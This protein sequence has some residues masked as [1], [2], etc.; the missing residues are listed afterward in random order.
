M[1][2]LTVNADPHVSYFRNFIFGVEDSLVSTVGLLSGIAV[3]GLSRA[4]IVITGAVLI[5]VEA[6]SMAAGSYLS[7]YS[8]ESYATHSE[9]PS[10]GD[11]VS[12]LIMFFSYFVTGFIP[13]LPY[14]FWPSDSALWVS[15][16]F[17]IAALLLLGVVGAKVA[18]I[19]VLKNTLRMVLVGS[20]AIAVGMLAGEL[21][22]QMN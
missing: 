18:R 15:V 22:S 19:H 12:S 2:K 9:T 17:S 10:R 14:V 11:F 8:A 6:F 13:L 1:A 3:A 4:T 16:A 20:L 7:E 21:L 5:L